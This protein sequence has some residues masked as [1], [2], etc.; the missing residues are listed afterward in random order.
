MTDDPHMSRRGFLRGRF[1]GAISAGLDGVRLRGFE[2]QSSADP[3]ERRSVVISIPVL[4]PPRAVPEQ[5]FLDGCTRCNAC[6]EACPHDAIVLAPSR[7][8][9]AAGTPMI[10]PHKQPCWM[11]H[12]TPCVTA[13]EPRVLDPLRRIAMGTASVDTTS[14][15]AYQGSFCTVCSERC[16]V[17]DAIEV[18]NG[19]PEIREVACTGCGICLH[20]CPAP[21]NAILLTPARVEGGSD[22]GKPHTD[23]DVASA[24]NRPRAPWELDMNL[25]QNPFLDGHDSPRQSTL[26]DHES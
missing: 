9:E 23:D 8:R 19:R 14:C 2:G 6:I 11:C 17:P 3:H 21:E 16:P 25:V 24:G 12:D 1:L 20:V 18:V 13:C 4:R 5:Q 15:L 10:D 7:L 26:D 22:D